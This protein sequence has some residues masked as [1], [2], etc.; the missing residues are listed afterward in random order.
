M[1]KG[2]KRRNK[3]DATLLPTEQL[4]EAVAAGVA[5]VIDP[6]SKKLDAVLEQ[7]EAGVKLD[8]EELE[9]IGIETPE[10]LGDVL[11]GAVDTAIADLEESNPVAAAVIESGIDTT[12]VVEEL[13]KSRKARKAE[14][15]ELEPVTEEEV[16]EVIEMVA[17]DIADELSSEEVQQ[18]VDEGV[19][20]EEAAKE[21]DPKDPEAKRRKK[22]S[23]RGRKSASTARQHK[24]RANTP[25][26]QRKYA[27]IFMS[28]KSSQI[29]QRAKKDKE[30]PPE[31]RFARAIK[32]SDYFAR[33]GSLLGG[34]ADPE[35]AAYAAKRLYKDEAL[36][37]AFKAMTV[38]E[39]T[40]GGVLVPQDW[41]DDIIPML[42]DNTVLFELGA[43]KIPMRH[44]NLNLPRQKSGARAMWSGEARP[45]P[46]STPMFDWLHL[47]AKRLGA[48]VVS[49]QELMRSTDI[50]ADIMFGRDM[51]Q[52]IQL[53]IN[54]GGLFGKGGEYQPMGVMLNPRVEAVDML[55]VNDT[56]IADVAGRPRQD[57]P[58]FVKGKVLAKNVDGAS[59]GWTFNSETEQYF[60]RMKN[61]N[62]DYVWKEEMDTR[63]F[64]G[65][66]Y[67]TTNQ[68]ETDDS[69]GTTEAVFGEWSSM[70]VGEQFGLE[71]E[72]T[73]QA[74]VITD[75]GTVN[76]FQDRATATVGT[77]YVDMGNRYDESFV[78]IRNLKVRN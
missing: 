24:R 61:A 69:T 34:F 52:Q 33:G 72:T 64:N 11:E 45:V 49:T 46:A 67:R 58:I 74:T 3:N 25:P 38:T 29:E 14:G 66:P 78:R 57:F 40:A 20:D 39:A 6:L 18:L 53:G 30:L 75:G 36:S 47:S 35:R 21:A 5:Q 12:E 76:T 55:T 68:F 27:D 19:L 48:L 1:A 2:R 23:A 70:V 44:G 43:Q 77:V 28:S 37:R 63:L 71:T 65:D 10:E 54:H 56:T 59:F 15:E 50:S 22:R 42:Y 13:V 7:Q 16:V 60:K 31:A 51:I 32:C 9:L 26:V 4:A 41:V 8:G 62:G 17:E 73:T